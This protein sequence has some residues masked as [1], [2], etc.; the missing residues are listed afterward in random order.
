MALADKLCGVVLASS[1]GMALFHRERSG[2]GQELH[3]PMLETLVAFNLADH[4]WEGTFGVPERGLGYPR[5]FAAQR[6]PHRTRDGYVS[7]HVHTDAQWRRL[8]AAIGR[9]ELAEDPRFASLAARTAHIE[10]LYDLVG[11]AMR[12]RGTAEWCECLRAADIPSGPMNDMAALLEN[13]HLHE[14][15]FFRRLV[16]PDGTE[17]LTT[18]VPVDFSAT[19]GALR[20]PPPALGQ[21]THELL[22]ALGYG[23]AEIAEITAGADAEGRGRGARAAP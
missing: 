14:T 11:E 23:A 7:L 5:M 12:E 16:H 13:P 18:D 20:L 15:G 2:R 9:P 17:Q 6:R 21:H 4:L 3:V 22:A 8:F 1:I 19:P 10:A